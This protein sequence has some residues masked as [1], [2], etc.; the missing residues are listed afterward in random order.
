MAYVEL[1]I[2]GE[3]LSADHAAAAKYVSEFADMVA[4]RNYSPQEVYN[5]D[6]TDLNFKP[7]P[8]KSLASKKEEKQTLSPN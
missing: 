5:A 4:G 8:K 6:V 3:R 7:L 2:M 1:S